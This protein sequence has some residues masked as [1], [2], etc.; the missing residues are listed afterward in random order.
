[1]PLTYAQKTYTGGK[2][3]AYALLWGENRLKLGRNGSSICHSDC[4]KIKN[5]TP[6]S[7]FGIVSLPVTWEKETYLPYET[8]VAARSRAEAE[9]I[10][11]AVLKAQLDTLLGK[12]GSVTSERLASAV[13]GDTLLVTLSAECTEQIGREVPIAIN[14]G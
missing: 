7:L 14:E 11:A 10:G 1:M 13:Q 8:A 6:W 4:D 12:D 5:Q 3:H 2:K 9:E